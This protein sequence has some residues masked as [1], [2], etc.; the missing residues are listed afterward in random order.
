M[1]LYEQEQQEL[2]QL[3]LSTPDCPHDFDYVSSCGEKVCLN[4]G[5]IDPHPM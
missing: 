2:K 3:S 4:C 5:V 1:E